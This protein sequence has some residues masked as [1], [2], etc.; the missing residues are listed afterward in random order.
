MVAQFD[1]DGHSGGEFEDSAGS[2]S[3]EKKIMVLGMFWV[4]FEED[5]VAQ[6]LKLCFR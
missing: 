3:G 2:N 4:S 1:F 5:F 6:E